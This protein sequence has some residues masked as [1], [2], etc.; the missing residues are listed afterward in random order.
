[1]RRR[2]QSRRDELRAGF[3]DGS[4]AASDP[5]RAKTSDHSKPP[6]PFTNAFGDV[7]KW[8]NLLRRADLGLVRN[9]VVQGEL[10]DDVVDTPTAATHF[11]GRSSPPPAP[12]R[13]A[14]QIDLL[15]RS[16]PVQRDRS[17]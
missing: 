9:A 6:Q 11:N 16:G 5:S 10:A 2:S 4:H 7:S 1:M 3:A 14:M 17:R 15:P 8:A 12:E 13:G